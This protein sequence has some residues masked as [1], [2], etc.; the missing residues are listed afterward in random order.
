MHPDVLM[1]FEKKPQALPLYALLE[2][3]LFS[4]GADVTCKVQKTQ[5]SF[6]NKRMFACIS[7]LPVMKSLPGSYITLTFGAGR[8]IEHE[9]IAVV[10][11]P[12]PGRFTH[13]VVLTAAEDMNKEMMNWLQEAAAFA[14]KK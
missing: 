1:F 11:E 5:I 4:L 2:K 9:R 10:A 12:Y 3:K 14:R 6:F 13:H 8:R 7:F